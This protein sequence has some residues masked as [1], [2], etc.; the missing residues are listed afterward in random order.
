MICRGKPAHPSKSTG[1]SPED[2]EDNER[3]QVTTSK[4]EKLA[5]QDYDDDEGSEIYVPNKNKVMMIKEKEKK[6][7]KPNGPRSRRYPR[8]KEVSERGADEESKND[9]GSPSLHARVR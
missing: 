6:L 8:M 7:I 9:G 4:H 2:E 5:G 1:S 3:A